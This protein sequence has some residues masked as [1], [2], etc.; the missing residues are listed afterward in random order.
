VLGEGR[1]QSRVGAAGEMHVDGAVDRFAHG[2]AHTASGPGDDY[3]DQGIYSAGGY[4]R[5]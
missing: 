3:A 5:L 4:E 1:L 2:L